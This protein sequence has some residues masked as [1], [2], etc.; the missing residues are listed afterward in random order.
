MGNSEE[1]VEVSATRGLVEAQEVGAKRQATRGRLRLAAA[2]LEAFW[3][4][5]HAFLRPPPPVSLHLHTVAAAI[6]TAVAP[7]TSAP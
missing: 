5:P 6:A 7:S 3:P 1:E 2:A 4:T